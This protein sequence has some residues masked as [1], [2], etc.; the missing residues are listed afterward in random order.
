MKA[1][2]LRNDVYDV[3]I[4]QLA[5]ATCDGLEGLSP[6]DTPVRN[7]LQQFGFDL[8]THPALVDVAKHHYLF[9]PIANTF[10]LGIYG[11]VAPPKA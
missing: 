1:N 7:S 4:W 6:E 5:C 3:M 9:M 2:C 8:M 11:M 10:T